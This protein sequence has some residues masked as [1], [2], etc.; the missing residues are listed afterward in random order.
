MKEVWEIRVRGE[1]GNYEPGAALQV[2]PLND[3]EVCR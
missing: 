2:L 3:K 1:F